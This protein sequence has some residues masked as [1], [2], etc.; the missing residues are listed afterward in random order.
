MKTRAACLC[1]FFAFQGAIANAAFVF[2]LEFV[3]QTTVTPG[4]TATISVLFRE[5]ATA[6]ETLRLNDATWGLTAANFVVNRV[7]STGNNNITS[8][9]KDQRFDG[10]TVATFTPSSASFP[11]IAQNNTPVGIPGLT[12]STL[13]LG[14]FNVTGGALGSVATFSIGGLTANDFILGDGAPN[15][16]LAVGASLAPLPSITVSAVPEPSSILL[17]GVASIGGF[18]A[19][20]YRK[21]RL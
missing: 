15:G 1:V 20:W 21:R 16:P 17:L 8:A 4:S 2:N 18:A 11:L 12:T 6:G 13:L 10:A 14:T 7:S 19:R 3:G 9:I 5:T